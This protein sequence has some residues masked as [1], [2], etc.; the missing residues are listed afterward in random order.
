MWHVAF[1][2]V[3]I[4]ISVC[5]RVSEQVCKN[6]R[7]LVG[8]EQCCI[9]PLFRKDN[10]MSTNSS[11]LLRTPCTHSFVQVHKRVHVQVRVY[12]SNML[13]GLCQMIKWTD[14][15]GHSS[16]YTC[17]RLPSRLCTRAPLVQN[18]SLVS[19]LHTCEADPTSDLFLTA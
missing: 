5:K 19:W 3:F 14:W 16:N 9:E 15:F 17:T 10:F 12:A 6:S 7:V 1:S 13:S 2:S 18:Y 4:S 11:G 8:V